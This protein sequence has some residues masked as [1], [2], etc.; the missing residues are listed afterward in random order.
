LEWWKISVDVCRWYWIHR[1]H[2]EYIFTSVINSHLSRVLTPN[3]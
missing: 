1:D 3:S 2:I